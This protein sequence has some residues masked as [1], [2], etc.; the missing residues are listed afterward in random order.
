LIIR[1]FVNFAV[2][3]FI[4][5][6]GYLTKLDC[7]D[8]K[9]IWKRI[10]RVLFPYVIWTLVFSVLHRDRNVGY[11]LLTANQ[12]SIFYFMI[13]YMELV[14][15]TPLILRLAK[16][17]FWMVGFAFT[18]I[19]IMLTRYLPYLGVINISDIL[20]R[21]NCFEWFLYYYLGI[22]IGNGIIHI[23]DGQRWTILWILSVALSM[24]EGLAWQ[25]F[26][27]NADMAT[28]QIR[29][30]SMLNTSVVC[31][32]AS[33]FASRND[34]GLNQ[35]LEKA[36]IQLGNYSFGIYLVHFVVIGLF[37]HF[38]FKIWQFPLSAI[39]TLASSVMIIYVGRK[40]VNRKI[41]R[42]IGF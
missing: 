17:R 9:I 6:S 10:S 38:H 29:F 36:L 26:F 34:S 7:I 2:G 21:L 32:M 28:S 42:L 3:L 1:P 27:G 12:P 40:V 16:S 4:F 15:L 37:S 41:C 11:N 24:I 13:V 39:I 31:M 23:R 8:S 22:L 14:V 30:S 20:V 25:S 35:R 18:P 33:I 5:L 19:M